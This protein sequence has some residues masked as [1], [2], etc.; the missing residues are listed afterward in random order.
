M[1]H[2]ERIDEGTERF[3]LLIRDAITTDDS[4]ES[5]LSL[6]TL[7]REMVFRARRYKVISSDT[8]N[9]HA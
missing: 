8:E 1:R 9:S 3:L 5:V 6:F 2:E 7:N 4:L